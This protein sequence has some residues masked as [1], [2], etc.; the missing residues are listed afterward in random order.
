MSSAKLLKY[1]VE[2]E[3]G[4][5]VRKTEVGKGGIGRGDGFLGFLG[6]VLKQGVDGRAAA[7]HSRV[8][9]TG[10]QQTLFDGSEFG[11]SREDRALEVVADDI[12]VAAEVN[13][14]DLLPS[15]IGERDL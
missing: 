12:P 4:F 9:R 11:M 8:V 15:E 2:D 13:G 10:I 5:Q 14:R 7:G 3:Q 1:I 6:I